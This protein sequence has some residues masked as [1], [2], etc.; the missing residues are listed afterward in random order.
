[1]REQNVNSV[2]D[3]RTCKCIYANLYDMLISTFYILCRSKQHIDFCW[4]SFSTL[5]IECKQM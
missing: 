4:N 1:M 3:G 5:F 2:D